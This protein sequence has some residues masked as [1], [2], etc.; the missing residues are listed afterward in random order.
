MEESMYSINN[1]KTM[2][3]IDIN[4]GTKIGFIKDLMV[5]CSEYKI[6]SLIIPSQK[7]SWFSKNDVIEVTWEKVKKIGVDVILV[8]LDEE[9]LRSREI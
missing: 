7:I 3:V 6:L 5:D 4:T 2:E 1:L 9:E 8:E